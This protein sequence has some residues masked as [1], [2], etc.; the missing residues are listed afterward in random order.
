MGLLEKIRK[1]LGFSKGEE[2]MAYEP[3]K[4][5]LER[6]P[7]K[8]KNVNYIE[9]GKLRQWISLEFHPYAWEQVGLLVYKDFM[10]YGV[11]FPKVKDSDKLPPELVMSID[12]ALRIFY[13]KGLP[14]GE[15]VKQ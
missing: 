6:T 13:N 1:L 12:K 2:G 8:G 14:L 5:E 4:E 3:I 15:L 10:D 7:V 11:P 9:A